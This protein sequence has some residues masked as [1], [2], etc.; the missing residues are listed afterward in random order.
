MTQ[1]DNL[2]TFAD[3][4]L[5]G[6]VAVVRDRRDPNGV[7]Q[8]GFRW[9]RRAV[10]C[11]TIAYAGPLV[12]LLCAAEWFA[13]RNW[14]LWA[15]LYAPPQV[16]LL[17]IVLLA[18]PTLLFRPRECLVYVACVF[19]VL[20]VYMDFK[21]S[22]WEP[23]GQSA[24]RVLTNNIGQKQG[25]RL[26]PFVEREKPD[27]IAL[28]EAQGRG[29]GYAKQYAGFNT[30]YHGEFIVASRFAIVESG[31]VEDIK[32]EGKPVA[33]RFVLDVHGAPVVVYNVHLPSP[34]DDL[35]RVRGRRLVGE[36][37]RVLRLIS[38]TE[39]RPVSELVSART[40]LA[41]RLA[42]R[43]RGE[44]HPVLLAGDLNV[45]CHGV[46]YHRFASFLT[47]VFAAKGRGYGYTFPGETRN[48]LTLFG[49][50]LRLDY[51]M[52]GPGWRP[53][54]CRAEPRRRSQHRAVVA[55]LERVG[56]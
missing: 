33:A 16:L 26:T 42:D 31:P 40:E 23:G 3:R 55:R 37:L 1:P 6:V 14:L 30:G 27:I 54:Y 49:P 13:E 9:L 48:P 53:L 20:V 28:Q 11:A 15:F 19:L 39:G 47:D 52:A 29:P 8:T 2:R 32:W 44:H 50:W 18:P 24:V 35:S 10:T 43:V 56:D 46:V 36:L 5:D 45:P 25:H 38:R 12:V 34:R 51:V 4:L 17:P 7:V 22:R 21:W 41:F